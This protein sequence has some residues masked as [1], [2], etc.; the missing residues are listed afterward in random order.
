MLLLEMF[1]SQYLKGIVLNGTTMFFHSLNKGV[2][3]TLCAAGSVPVHVEKTLFLSTKSMGKVDMQKSQNKM[4][5]AI[6]Y[7]IQ[8]KPRG[9]PQRGT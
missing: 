1:F 3:G 7:N 5:L 8:R 9:T 4:I 6:M 2:L